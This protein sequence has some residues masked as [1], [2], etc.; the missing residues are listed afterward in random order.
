MNLQCR[1]QFQIALMASTYFLGYAIGASIYF[2][3]DMIGRKRAI[4]FSTTFNLIAE[5][6]LLWNSDYYVRM[7]AFFF[8]GLF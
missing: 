3:P 6:V 5:T 2:L 8:M 4:I 1:T 7:A